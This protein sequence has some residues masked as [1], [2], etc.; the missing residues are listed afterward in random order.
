M[1][2]I[3]SGAA[4]LSPF[5]RL[6]RCAPKLSCVFRRRTKARHKMYSRCTAT[7]ADIFVKCTCAPA[8]RAEYLPF[9][10][11]IPRRPSPGFRQKCLRRCRTPC[12]CCRCGKAYKV[13]FL[14]G[15]MP[16]Y[17]DRSQRAKAFSQCRRRTAAGIPRSLPWRHNIACR[18]CPL[19]LWKSFR[20]RGTRQR[21]QARCRRI[22]RYRPPT[23][24]TGSRRQRQYSRRFPFR[25]R[26]AASPQP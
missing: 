26:A 4:K 19:L 18:D 24:S 5:R 6:S 8:S 20:R 17:R 10:S 7:A 14:C 25:R 9:Q 22:S 21:S 16:Q 23:C 15:R 12:M 3:C 11:S 2:H 1:K 13:R